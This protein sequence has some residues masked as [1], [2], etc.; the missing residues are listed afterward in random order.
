VG[1]PEGHRHD[2][3]GEDPDLVI[4]IAF[5]SSRRVQLGEKSGIWVQADADSVNEDDWQLCGRSVRAVPVGSVLCGRAVHGEE[6]VGPERE[7]LE[8]LG[9]GGA[10][11]VEALTDEHNVGEQI[12]KAHALCIV[13]C[14]GR[15]RDRTHTKYQAKLRWSMFILSSV[16]RKAFASPLPGSRFRPSIFSIAQVNSS[17]SSASSP[18]GPPLLKN[19]HRKNSFTLSLLI[20][21]I[22]APSNH[23]WR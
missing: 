9:D 11:E 19:A 20:S 16:K 8:E 10:V 6:R 5:P 3:Y 18:G 1:E 17:K 21:L 14:C 22:S 4:G 2:F 13:S 12:D 15:N 7:Q 23:F